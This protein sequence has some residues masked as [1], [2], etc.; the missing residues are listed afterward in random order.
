MKFLVA[1]DGSDASD[2]AIDYVVELARGLD[3]AVTVVHAVEPGVSVAGDD[4]SAPNDRLVA[5][6]M[7]D[8][9]ARG[10]RLVDDA[11]RRLDAA[12]VDA[13]AELLYGDPANVVPDFAAAESFDGL[14]VG[15]RG[16]SERYENLVGSVAKAILERSSV[17]VT[18]VR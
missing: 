6:S 12:G 10:E 9:E 7:E 18:V 14:F 15:H 17:P 8:A 3:A 11:V 5:E 16:L 13:E 4:A 2:E 1:V